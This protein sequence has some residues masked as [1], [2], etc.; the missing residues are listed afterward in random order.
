MAKPHQILPY[1]DPRRWLWAIRVCGLLAVGACSESNDDG[2][3]VPSVDPQQNVMVIDDGIDLSA[4]DLHGKVVAAFTRECPSEPVA[5]GGANDG[6]DGDSGGDNDGGNDAGTSPDGGSA[7]SFEDRKREYI[8]SLLAPSRCHLRA[9]I[10]PKPT[11]LASVQRFRDRWNAMLRR[12]RFVNDTFS[13]QEWG[14]LE[15]ALDAEFGAFSFHGTTTSGTVAHGN[16]GV[17]LVLID[18]ALASPQEAEDS[19]E[20]LVQSD[21]D[22]AIALALDPEVRDAYTH[23]PISA[24]IEEFRS[25]VGQFNVGVINQSFGGRSRAGLEQLQLA[26]GCA[27]ISVAAYFSAMDDLDRGR[28][29]VIGPRP[30]LTVQ[31]AGNESVSID[32]AGDSSVCV[33]WDDR[34]LLVGSTG[35]APMLSTFSNLGACVDVFAPGEDIIAPYG[36]G[37]L[38]PVQGTSYSAPIAAWLISRTPFSPFD[39]VEA[40]RHLLDRRDSQ[41]MISATTFPRDF[42]YVPTV[43]GTRFGALT[44]A[45][46]SSGGL[47]RSLARRVEGGRV[48]WADPALWLLRRAAKRGNRR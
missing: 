24:Y 26:R 13:P 21:I 32:S 29:D 9:G 33:P 12:Q 43:S 34:H 7:P 4:A 41:R 17:R 14:E 19:F 37:W 6:G 5:D 25:I 22:Q 48:D 8:A 20:C 46:G 3:A 45:D 11:P 31:S 40:R 39:P 2:P 15:A 47:G 36:G 1:E 10:D 27:T 16:S 28:S 44:S 35:F 30:Y 23:A 42:F 38:L 18:I